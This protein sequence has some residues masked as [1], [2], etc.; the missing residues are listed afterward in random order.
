MDCLACGKKIDWPCDEYFCSKECEQF[1]IQE[2][3]E[4]FNKLDTN[5]PD[6]SFGDSDDFPDWPI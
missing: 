3:E 4:M 1:Y 2:L 6:K 5:I